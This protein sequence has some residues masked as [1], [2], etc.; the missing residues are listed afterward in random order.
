M[1]RCSILRCFIP[2]VFADDEV[3]AQTENLAANTEEGKHTGSG[4]NSANPDNATTL[5]YDLKSDR[6][7]YA[8]GDNNSDDDHAGGKGDN[9]TVPFDLEAT[10]AYGANDRSDDD[11]GDDDEDNDDN[12]KTDRKVANSG[13]EPFEVSGVKGS[14]SQPSQVSNPEDK[15]Q[16]YGGYDDETDDEDTIAPPPHGHSIGDREHEANEPTLAYDGLEATQAYGLDDNSSDRSSP[17]LQLF[18]V[19]TDEERGIEEQPTVAYG[20]DETQAYGADEPTL[21]YPVQPP[22]GTLYCGVKKRQKLE[23]KQVNSIMRKVM[24]VSQASFIAAEAKHTCYLEHW[25]IS[26]LRL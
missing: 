20:L 21:A 13:T 15:T 10:Q 22:E 26:V 17:V 23:I 19:G 8:A 4:M 1:H 25:M 11:D 7:A 16:A 12:E 6:Y 3:C 18:K 9:R 5:A 24:L 2:L 14:S